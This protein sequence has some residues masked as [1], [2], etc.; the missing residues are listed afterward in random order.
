MTLLDSQQTVTC[1]HTIQHQPPAVGAKRKE[2]EV[3]NSL[4]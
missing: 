1:I 3:V 4:P 2:V